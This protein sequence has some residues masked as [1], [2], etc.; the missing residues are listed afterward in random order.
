MV[1]SR[2]MFIESPREIKLRT[3]NVGEGPSHSLHTFNTFE[4]TGRDEKPS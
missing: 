2:E 1:K 3:A 4:K